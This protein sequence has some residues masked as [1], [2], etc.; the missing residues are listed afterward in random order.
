MLLQWLQGTGT[1]R[2]PSFKQPQEQEICSHAAFSSSTDSPAMVWKSTSDCF[3]TYLEPLGKAFNE[4]GWPAASLQQSHTCHPVLLRTSSLCFSSGCCSQPCPTQGQLFLTPFF[5]FPHFI[6]RGQGYRTALACKNSNYNSAEEVPDRQSTTKHRQTP[7]T[8]ATELETSV[9]ASREPRSC[10]HPDPTQQRW[11]SNGSECTS[12][13]SAA[14]HPGLQ[15]SHVEE[16]GKGD[17]ISPT[18]RRRGAACP[19]RRITP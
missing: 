1:T 6:L 16:M 11:H 9:G 14:A 3:S 10:C 18:G 15:P 8:E 7:C 2:C 4:K 17:R 5:F 12:R 19:N 13:I